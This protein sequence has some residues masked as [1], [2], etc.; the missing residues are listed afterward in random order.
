GHIRRQPSR[1]LAHLVLS[2]IDEAALLVAN[3]ENTE[4]ARLEA[5]LALQTLLGSLE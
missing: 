1:S 5:N 4:P 2:I 3:A